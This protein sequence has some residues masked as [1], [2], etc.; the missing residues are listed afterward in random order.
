MLA[1][2][3]FDIPWHSLPEYPNIL[4]IHLHQIQHTGAS[5]D[6]PG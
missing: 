4:S 1:N 6:I 5:D 2:Q 3:K